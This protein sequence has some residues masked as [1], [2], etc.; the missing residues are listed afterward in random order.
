MD[1]ASAC[2]KVDFNEP[3]AEA[4]TSRA[5]SVWFTVSPWINPANPADQ[6]T[7]IFGR[8]R[9]VT[10]GLDE[11]VYVNTRVQFPSMD[12]N[13]P[14]DEERTYSNRCDDHH[15]TARGEPSGVCARERSQEHE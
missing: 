10:N 6:Q 1:P 9:Q 15:V 3:H 2:L 8:A 13:Y 7:Q 11:L 12:P 5:K 14:G 4:A